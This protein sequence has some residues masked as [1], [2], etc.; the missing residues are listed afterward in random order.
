MKIGLSQGARGPI[1]ARLQRILGLGRLLGEE[2]ERQAFG[3]TTLDALH[4][5]QRR[6]GLPVVD[7]IDERTLSLLLEVEQNITINLGAQP[8]RPP[9]PQP[10]EHHG[11]VSGKFVD[12]D[13][14]PLAGRKVALLS[15][16]L[17]SESEL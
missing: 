1:V 17:R 3:P 11:R 12:Q 14:S 8:S 4:V 13:G 10:D 15:K 7:V 2:V 5:L 6:H 9:A 16:L